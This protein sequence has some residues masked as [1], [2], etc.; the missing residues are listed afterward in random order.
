MVADVE[1]YDARLVADPRLQ[2]YAR[3]LVDRCLG[4]QP[5]WQVTIRASPLGRPLV[6]AVVREVARR[7]AWALPRYSYGHRSSPID[8]A[9]AAEAPLELL[10]ELAPVE[11]YWVENDDARLSIVAPENTR[12]L[13]ALDTERRA[14]MQRSL[15]P[16]MVRSRAALIPWCIC[17]YPT[18]ALAQDAGMTLREFE[19]VLYG[20]CLVDWDAMG[21]EMRRVAARFDAGEEVR[22]VGHETDLTL[23][24]AGRPARVSEGRRNM[25]DGEFFY[26]PVEESAEGVITY[27]EFPAAFGGQVVEGARLVFR[28]GRVVDA[29][30]RSN[31]QFLLDTL[32][33]DDGAR[34]LGELG[35]GCNTGIQR[36]MQNVLFDEKIAGT[37]HLA[38]GA[39][40]TDIGGR[41]ESVI[42]WDMVKDLRDGG[43]IELDGELV[44]ENGR[45]LV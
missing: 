4:V 5:R 31:E 13:A 42:H 23:S 28:E 32:D 15:E 8:L 20:A 29:S 18:P 2:E 26:A 27:S 12:D 45:W 35:I 38:L 22:I 30:A 33:T 25:P 44:Q 40:Y 36:Y 11:R 43:R 9:W 24:I 39:S 41:N 19:E 6:E 34:R 3:L 16:M 7:G 14:A 10:E 37:V 1:S 21:E 17:Q